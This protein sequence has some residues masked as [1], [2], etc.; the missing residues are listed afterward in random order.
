MLKQISASLAAL[1]EP[2]KTASETPSTNSR[3]STQNSAAA[4]ATERLLSFYPPLDVSEPKVFIAGI[5]N[6]LAQYPAELHEV[7]VS[8]TGIPSRIKDLRNIFEINQ[9]C[10]EL[11]EPIARRITREALENQPRQITKQRTAEEQAR[12]D[13]QVAAWRF[14]ANPFDFS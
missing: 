2:R 3:H 6:V 10:R 8:P 14:R 9:V 1:S 13:A 4:L 11:Y 5:V 12:I 7:V